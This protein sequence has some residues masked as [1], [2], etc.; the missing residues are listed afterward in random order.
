MTEQLEHLG[1]LA[2]Q[3][4]VRVLS[5]V[6]CRQEMGPREDQPVAQKTQGTDIS[7]G[8]EGG[9]LTPDKNLFPL[10]YA[11]YPLKDERG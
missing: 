4:V 9:P 7:G 6:S 5:P 11:R 1:T 10:L 3:G 2:T 8:L